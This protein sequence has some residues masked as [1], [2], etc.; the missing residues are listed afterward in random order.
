MSLHERSTST[1]SPPEE[2]AMRIPKCILAIMMILATVL[3]CLPNR[4]AARKGKGNPK[5]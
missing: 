4:S 1:E 3:R 2:E 5:S